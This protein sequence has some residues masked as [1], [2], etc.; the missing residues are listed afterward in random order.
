MGR[1][2]WLCIACA[3]LGGA[4]QAQS[5]SDARGA[6]KMAAPEGPTGPERYG[7]PVL[8]SREL[9][10]HVSVVSLSGRA[11][12]PLLRGLRTVSRAKEPLAVD[13][14]VPNA[15]VFMFGAP[16]E[17]TR[18]HTAHG[19][20]ALRVEFVGVD[21]AAHRR[22]DDVVRASH[23]VVVVLK[24]DEPVADVA[25]ALKTIRAGMRADRADQVALWLEGE[26]RA[27]YPAPV[28][29]V[30]KGGGSPLLSA[31]VKTIRSGV[32]PGR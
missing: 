22:L 8:A 29:G 3:A 10:S 20:Y 25:A 1:R 28:I 24:G 23:L 32:A 27:P 15:D 21:G 9:I 31:I 12:E 19:E 17:R 16:I 26:A 5:K 13:D 11:A 6:A 2:I 4:A 30:G 18:V 7:V 14:E